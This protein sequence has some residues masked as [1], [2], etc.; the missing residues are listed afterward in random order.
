[1]LNPYKVLEIS[2]KATEEEVKSAFR[3]LAKATHPDLNGGDPGATAQF[4]KVAEAYAILSDP[5]KKREVDL[6]L[7]DKK[8]NHSN[9]SGTV[10][11]NSVAENDEVK[12]TAQSIEYAIHMLYKEVK[13][14]K[15]AALKALFKGLAWLIGGILVTFFSYQAAAN[16]GGGTYFVMYGAVIFGGIQA[17]RGFICYAK[18][19][20]VVTEAESELWSKI[21]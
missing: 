12:I 15:A 3:R 18:I 16:N 13:P 21:A 17:I 14:Y 9:S 1:M 10:K 20:S 19:Q 7:N 4:R 11:T 6:I 5:I 2:N 8:V